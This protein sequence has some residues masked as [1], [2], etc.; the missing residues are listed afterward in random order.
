MAQF[1]QTTASI[2]IP[3]AIEWSTN[4][5]QRALPGQY[6]GADENQKGLLLNPGEMREIWIQVENNTHA[7]L[8]YSI[9]VKGDFPRE[10]YLGN[11]E[12]S[13]PIQ[14]N[15]RGHKNLNFQVAADFFENQA[16]LQLDHK[17]QLNYQGEISIYAELQGER[18]LIGYQHFYIFVRPNSSYIDLLP[19]IYGRSDFL[20]R[21][22]T[23]F[24]EGYDP[25]V[26]TLT[27]LWAYLDPL[28]A[29][30]AM[31]PFLA[32]WVAWEMNPRWELKQQ[33][34]L[35]RNAVDL[36]RWRGSRRGVRLYIQLFTGL[37]EEQIN[38]EESFNTSFV[39]GQAN[40]RGNPTLGGG[41]A[42]HFTVTLYPRSVDEI[43]EAL[44]HEV[45][46]EAKPAFCT[47]DL[48]VSVR[49]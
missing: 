48:L 16:A 34:R 29:P 47:Y 33:R 30:K 17:L 8:Q 42:F 32:K 31:L 10:W 20:K 24:E 3:S 7:T 27:H 14:P 45:I 18:R 36:Y 39:L 25:S 11:Q 46:E 9:E 40:L 23:I 1:T 15:N 6:T 44:I 22:L 5:N 4:Q 13:E 49:V 41:K 2:T 28:T 12:I 43:D 19:E 21:L 37:A 26:Q 38:I 35:I